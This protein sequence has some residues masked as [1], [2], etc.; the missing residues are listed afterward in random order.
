MYVVDPYDHRFFKM[1][2]EAAPAYNHH[3]LRKSTIEI[4]RKAYKTLLVLGL[5]M[6]PL[7]H[8]RAFGALLI[9]SAMTPMEIDLVLLRLLNLGAPKDL[10]CYCILGSW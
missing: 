10:C 3:K 4:P 2:S 8:S 9:S 7:D 1:F 6:R 5:V